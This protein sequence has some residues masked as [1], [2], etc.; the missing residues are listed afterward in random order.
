MKRNPIT[1][2]IGLLL[3]FIFGLLLVFYQVRTTEVAMVTTFGKPTKPVTQ[4]G[5]TRNGR[6]QSSRCTN[7]TTDP[8]F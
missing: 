8:E 5:R 6:G 1:I 3:L 2:T 7:L 4:P